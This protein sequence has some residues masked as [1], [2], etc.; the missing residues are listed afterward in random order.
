MC[1]SFAAQGIPLAGSWRR[2][3]GPTDEARRPCRWRDS[4][5]CGW[6]EPQASTDGVG[7]AAERR[8]SG[9]ARI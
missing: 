3:P 6:R 8:R 7:L 4:L 5:I 9:R 1:G 2:E